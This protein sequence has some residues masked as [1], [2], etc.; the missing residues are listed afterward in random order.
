MNLIKRLFL[1]S[2]PISWVNTAY[3]FAV[4]YLVTTGNI[5]LVW[6]IGVIHFLIPYN[7]LMYGINDVF[8]YESDLR[9]PRKTG[10]EGIV[11]ERP[12]HRM[13]IITALAANTPFIIYLMVAGTTLSNILLIFITFF[14]IAYSAPKLRFKERPV[15]DSITSSIHFVGPMVYGL[16]LA[17]SNVAVW[18]CVASF[19][20][21]G[22]SSHAFGAV[23][24]IIPDRSAN[25]QSIATVLGAKTT[26]R[27]AIL[28]YIISACLLFA[29]KSSASIMGIVVLLYVINVWPY[30]S[31]SDESSERANK[32]WKRFLWINM[33]SGAVLTILLI[34]SNF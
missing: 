23:Q 22:I 29:T 7:L 13:V 30:I 1:T 25:I 17:Q 15:L 12:Y 6:F 31:I 18:P 19:F 10:V 26:V 28:C 21:W 2:R 33:I 11:L 3:P 20:L 8:D 9:N 24:D 16:A 32:G 5:N 34:A 27:F 4:A 14:V